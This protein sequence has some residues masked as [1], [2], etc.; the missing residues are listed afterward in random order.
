MRLPPERLWTVIL[1]LRMIAD[2]ERTRFAA[3]QMLGSAVG[4]DPASRRLRFV[5]STFLAEALERDPEAR[6]DLTRAEQLHNGALDE[7]RAL[8]TELD[9]PEARRD[10]AVSFLNLAGMAEARGD[11]VMARTTLRDAREAAEA[12]GQR[13]ALSDAAD[14]LAA[15][16]EALR[17]MS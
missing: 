13:Q 4:D 16:D 2:W 5:A 1:A 15:V 12:F 14:I 10:L 3:E 9:T 8:A 11:L 6:I 7:A 17:R